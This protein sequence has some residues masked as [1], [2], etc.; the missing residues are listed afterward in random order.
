M[1]GF[2]TEGGR[3]RSGDRFRCAPDRR[4]NYLANESGGA[5]NANGNYSVTPATFSIGPSASENWTVERLIIYVADT[6]QFSASEY[7]NTGSALANGF[8]VEVVDSGDNVIST[9]NGSRPFTT[10][11]DLGAVCYD[12]NNIGSGS[13]GDD[14]ILVRW[15]FSKAGSPIRLR[16]DEGWKVRVVLSDDF[17][18]LS[19]HTFFLDCYLT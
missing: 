10:N 16:G 5:T 4:S 12:V 14:A 19:A 11:G 1:S 7:G 17:S 13:G 2:I 15:T 9:L 8:D 6:G 18:G 3:P